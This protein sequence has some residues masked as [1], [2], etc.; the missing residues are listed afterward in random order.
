MQDS[1]SEYGAHTVDL[2][3]RPKAIKKLLMFLAVKEMSVMRT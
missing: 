2:K 3:E 1:F